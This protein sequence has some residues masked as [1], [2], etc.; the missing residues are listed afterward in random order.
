MPAVDSLLIAYSRGRRD[1]KTLRALALALAP[2]LK[3]PDEMPGLA[4]GDPVAVLDAVTVRGYDQPGTWQQVRA[5]RDFGRLTQAEY[6]YLAAAV[7]AL[8]QEDD[9]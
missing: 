4:A 8:M 6:D 1:S 2:E 3:T 9:G 5:A 7:E